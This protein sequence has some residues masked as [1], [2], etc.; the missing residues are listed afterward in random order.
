[1]ALTGHQA[2]DEIRYRTPVGETTATIL[3]IKAPG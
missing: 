2:G 3:S 1:M